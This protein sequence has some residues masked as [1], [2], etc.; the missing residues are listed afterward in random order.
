M[1]QSKNG[2]YVENAIKSLDKMNLAIINKDKKIAMEG[3][4]DKTAGY[5]V[6]IKQLV[7]ELKS[8]KP[9]HFPCQELAHRI[10]NHDKGIRT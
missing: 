5:I 10:V 2:L 6:V 8:T 4:T 1:P 7:S 3:T 9:E